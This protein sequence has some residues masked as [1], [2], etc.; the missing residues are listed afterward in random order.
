MTTIFL[1]YFH[2]HRN[3]A[4]VDIFCRHHVL[5]LLLLSD[6]CFLLVLFPPQWKAVHIPPFFHSNVAV[7]LMQNQNRVCTTAD[8]NIKRSAPLQNIPCFV[9]LLPWGLF[10][11]PKNVWVFGMDRCVRD[12]SLF[13]PPR[14][15]ALLR[16][17]LRTKQ[18]P[19][20]RLGLGVETHVTFH[21][22]IVIGADGAARLVEMTATATAFGGESHVAAHE[23][24]EEQVDTANALPVVKGAVVDVDTRVARVA[25]KRRGGLM[26]LLHQRR[27]R[28]VLLS[29]IMFGLKMIFAQDFLF[30]DRGHVVADV[31]VYILLAFVVGLI[32][33]LDNG[34]LHDA[35]PQLHLQRAGKG[36]GRR[37]INRSGGGGRGRRIGRVVGFLGHFGR[38]G[39]AQ[40]GE[41]AAWGVGGPGMLLQMWL[42]LP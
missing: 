31:V 19:P 30:A 13:R 6:N 5:L 14:M 27:R 10:H 29:M 12:V 34:L 4:L 36:R 40:D 39:V 3:Y 16:S 42:L 20:T 41:N 11:G 8:N 9:L 38:G 18:D 1:Y 22:H 35:H 17:V 37:H 23:P 15:D 2:S 7:N 21:L 25:I 24:F 33:H 32:D 28:Q 26:L